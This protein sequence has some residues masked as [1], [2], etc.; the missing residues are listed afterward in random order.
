LRCS[1]RRASSFAIASQTPE[2]SPATSN[3]WAAV[4]LHT[5]DGSV[6]ETVA[7]LRCVGCIADISPTWSLMKR[8]ATH[9]IHADIKRAR[10]DKKNIVVFVILLNDCCLGRNVDKL[11]GFSN[12]LGKLD[13]A[14]NDFLIPQYFD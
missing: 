9:A 1:R 8:R 12:A 11:C 6:A 3:N 7:T 5:T 14:G 2:N 13:I 10:N 4:S